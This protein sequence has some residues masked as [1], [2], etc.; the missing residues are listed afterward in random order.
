MC[1]HQAYLYI[2][3]SVQDTIFLG[4]RIEHEILFLKYNKLEMFKN[5]VDRIIYK[6]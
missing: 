3:Y 4:L 6:Y 1:N 2:S 5:I